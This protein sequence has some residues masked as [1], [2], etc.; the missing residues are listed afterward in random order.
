MQGEGNDAPPN[1]RMVMKMK[2]TT[3]TTI[4]KTVSVAIV[5]YLRLPKCLRG[6]RDIVREMRSA[7]DGGF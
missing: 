2:T 1:R 4:G 7:G 5:E 3:M 6:E